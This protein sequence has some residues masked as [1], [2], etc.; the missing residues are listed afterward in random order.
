MQRFERIV[1][2]RPRFEVRRA[3]VK[4]IGGHEH[5]PVRDTSARPDSSE[6]RRF[7][8]R[9]WAIPTACRASDPVCRA[10]FKRH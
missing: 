4:P 7:R 5:R 8:N 6:H 1:R 3:E 9:V 2:E 10:A